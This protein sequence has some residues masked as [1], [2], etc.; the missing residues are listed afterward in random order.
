[1]FRSRGPF[2]L[3]V[4][5]VLHAFPF[6]NAEYYA[7]LDDLYCNGP[8]AIRSSHY[9]YLSAKPDKHNGQSQ[10]IGNDELFFLQQYDPHNP[11]NVGLKTSHGTYFRA[12]QGGGTD[13]APTR[14][15]WESYR[16]LFIT[17][18]VVAFETFHRTFLSAMADGSVQ[19]SD[20]MGSNERFTLVCMANHAQ[21]GWPQQAQGAWPQQTQG[22]WAR[23][24]R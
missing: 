13:Q 4:F 11:D 9:L 12:I 20:R 15:G 21:G 18:N 10:A 23:G 14:Q 5:V 19:Q 24:W 7:S 8:F 16:L 3:F 6:L 17:N 2:I 22:G 1:M